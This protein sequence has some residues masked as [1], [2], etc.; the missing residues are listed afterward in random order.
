MVGGLGSDSEVQLGLNLILINLIL[1]QDFLCIG[2]CWVVLYL[3]LDR[4]TAK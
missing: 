4:T 3:P 1:E 2:L